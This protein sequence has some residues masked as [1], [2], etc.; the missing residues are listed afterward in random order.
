MTYTEDGV[1][2]TRPADVQVILTLQQDEGRLETYLRDMPSSTVTPGSSVTSA[3]FEWREADGRRYFERVETWSVEPDERP[4][5]SSLLGTREQGSTGG[6]RVEDGALPTAGT[7]S[8]AIL[9][10]GNTTVLIVA[11]DSETTARAVAA[12]VRVN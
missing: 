4:S 9:N 10:L 3:V 8:T 12:L 1:L 2:E 6:Q 5:A 7:T 11:P